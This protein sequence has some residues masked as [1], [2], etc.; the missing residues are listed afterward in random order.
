MGHWHGQ[1]WVPH[2][3]LSPYDY[4]SR[5]R[6]NFSVLAGY[7]KNGD[8]KPADRGRNSGKQ[9]AHFHMEITN[10]CR[11]EEDGG[12]F[13]MQLVANML[14]EICGFDLPYPEIF[15]AE[16]LL[17]QQARPLCQGL[18]LPRDFGHWDP[19][20]IRVAETFLRSH[21][22]Q[23]GASASTEQCT[24]HAQTACNISEDVHY[25]STVGDNFQHGR[26]E[27]RLATL[28]LHHQSA[29]GDS[30]HQ[31][32]AT[33][34]QSGLGDHTEEL[35]PAAGQAGEPVKLEFDAKNR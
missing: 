16:G 33:H 15:Y 3:H 32:H 22:Q 10:G 24:N 35:A 26:W 11:L 21:L 2:D 6:R 28:A 12:N 20:K 30:A 9:M 13:N 17:V 23:T 31:Q 4:G 34:H 1:R 19:D 5:T 25:Q 8:G 18:I 27:L 29:V 14:C 7:T